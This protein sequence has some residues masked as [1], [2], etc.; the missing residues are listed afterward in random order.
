MAKLII[1][2]WKMN[3]V[4]AGLKELE[5]MIAAPRGRAKLVIC[6][7]ATLIAG[8]AAAAEGSAVEIGAQDCH[9]K[10]AGAHTGDLSAEMLADVGARYILVGHSERRTDHG[11]T[12]ALVSAKAA[13]VLRAGVTP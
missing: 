8:F 6:P 4:S 5:A 2:N 7:P 11:E 12:D 1:G 10:A 13:A 9:V 3:G